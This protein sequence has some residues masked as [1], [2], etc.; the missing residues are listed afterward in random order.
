MPMPSNNSCL[1]RTLAYCSILA[2]KTIFY[3]QSAVA[4]SPDRPITII[5]PYTAG[6][7]TPDI[8]ARLVAAE[9]QTR[10]N[11]TVVV[12]NIPGASGNIGTRAAARAAPDGNT[13]VVVTSSFVQNRTLFKSIPYD[14]SQDFSPVIQL[15][16][17]TYGLFV[18]PAISA[19]NVADFVKQAKAAPGQFNFSTPG[20]GS[21]H[22]LLMEMFKRSTGTDL[23]HVPYKG[24]GPALQDLIGGHVQ[25]MFLPFSVGLP[26]VQGG[27]LKALGVADTTRLAAA[28][29]VPTLLEQ[30]IKGLDVRVWNGVLAPKG[31]P[32][33][34]VNRY[35]EVFNEILCSASVSK[36]LRDRNI[37]AVG[38]STAIFG[39]LI[40]RDMA[41]WAK[42]IEEAKITPE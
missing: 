2:A 32:T 16:D 5:V 18:H 25:A 30:G 12:E 4:Q 6:E 36:T 7:N 10:W 15:A 22:H 38:G 31:T 42:T 8:L 13:I 35:N 37:Q 29:E 21:P 11:H 33:S 1:V 3:G 23:L 41:F 17:I 27:K 20:R 39:A 14:P 26:L 19:G 28:A 40:E 9:I 24:L 34:I